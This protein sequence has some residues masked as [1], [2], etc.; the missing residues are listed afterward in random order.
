MDV[1]AVIKKICGEEKTIPS[2][3]KYLPTWMAW[4]RSFVDGFH[5][6]RQ[7]NGMGDWIPM[8]RKSLHMAKHVCE[9]WA[10]LLANEKCG[11][12]I[13]GKQNTIFQNVLNDTNFKGK[14]AGAI[15]KSFALSLGAFVHSVVGLKRGT[16]TGIIDATG[17]KT[18]WDFVIA[19]KVYPITIEDKIITECAFVCKNSDTTVISIHHK[20]P[21]GNYIIDN[22]VLND[23]NEIIA[24]PNVTY[25]FDT[26]SPLPWF[27]IIRPNI[28]SNLMDSMND[29]EIAISIFANSTDTLEAVDNKYDGFDIE[30]VAGRKRTYVSSKAWKMV[31]RTADG[32]TETVRTFDFFDPMFFSAPEDESGK[33]II[34]TQSD[35][36]RYDAYIRGI[37]IELSYLSSQCGL[38]ENYYKFDGTTIV[39]ATQV[40]SENSTLYRNIKKHE[41]LLKD[42]LRNI[43]KVT[44]Y[45]SNKFTA[46]PI[47]EVK[48]EDI[49]IDFDDSIIEDKGAQMDRDR[50]DVSAGLMTKVEYR[51]KWYGEDEKTAAEMIQKYFLYDIID[52]Y[53]NALTTG[54]MTPEQY[55][56]KVFP[57]DPKKAQIIKYITEFAV[58]SGQPDMNQLYPAN[59]GGEPNP[60]DDEEEPEPEV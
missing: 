21:N 19:T 22:V 5:T 29:D 18:K 49:I 28:E 32:V 13:P 10:N 23:K 31:K 16:S 59:E 15:E 60:K 8:K 33:P 36:L 27:Q 57:N 54:A 37:N 14:L 44:I 51:M 47:G 46:T 48:D 30:Y 58:P 41:A 9:S 38:G 1:N 35:T 6:Y 17:G 40:I 2:K 56:D 53:Q 4:Y 43:A 42:V 26:G 34:T 12:T 24:D 11:I 39:T 20:A 3:S 52:K 50:N 25:T 55:V 7:Y 45:A